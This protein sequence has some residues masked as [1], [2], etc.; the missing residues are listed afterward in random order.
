MKTI[1]VVHAG[2]VQ[3]VWSDHDQQVKLYDFDDVDDPE[4]PE[5]LN[6]QLNNECSKLKLIYPEEIE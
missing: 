3:E 1:I 5:R 4:R 6:E 2:V